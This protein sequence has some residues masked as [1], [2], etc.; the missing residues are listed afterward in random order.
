[1]TASIVTKF[2]FSSL[3]NVDSPFRRFRG[4][5]WMILSQKHERAERPRSIHRMCQVNFGGTPQFPTN[6]H[7]KNV[8]RIWSLL[9]SNTLS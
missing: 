7:K 6:V 1:M 2:D 9:V 3:V 5:V 4:E 8:P